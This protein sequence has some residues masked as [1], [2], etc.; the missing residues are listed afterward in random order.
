MPPRVPSILPLGTGVVAPSLYD[1]ER[2]CRWCVCRVPLCNCEILCHLLK[3]W[4]VKTIRA[5]SWTGP[6]S[7]L[8]ASLRSHRLRLNLVRLRL[9]GLLCLAG[10]G[11]CVLRLQVLASLYFLVL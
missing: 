3:G 11:G 6:S 5:V 7:T 1:R 2:K 9:L 10:W 8:Y 4:W